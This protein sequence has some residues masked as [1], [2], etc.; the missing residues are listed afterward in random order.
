MFVCGRGQGA[1]F[2]GRQALNAPPG[3]VTG[4]NSEIT[5]LGDSVERGEG[6]TAVWVHMRNVSY[7]RKEH[8][9]IVDG[10]KKQ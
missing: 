9:E 5:V 1:Q 2:W 10:K 4:G 8:F 7:G 6:R 3:S